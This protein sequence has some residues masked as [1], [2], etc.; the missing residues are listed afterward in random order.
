MLK[1][2]L[3]MKTQMKRM[4]S[5]GGLSARLSRLLRSYRLSVAASSLFVVA[6]LL[7]APTAKAQFSPGGGAGTG[8]ASIGSNSSYQPGPVNR[9]PIERVADGKVVSKTDTAMPG[10]VVYLKDAKSNSVKTYIA[11]DSG[12]FHFGQLSQNT[13]YTL[14]AES[15]GVKSKSKTIS[16]F[17]NR[18]SF[19][20]T[21]KVDGS[22]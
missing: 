12:H 7:C 6:G 8:G 3:F 5:R 15:N 21:L 20:F 14:W 16:S 4:S 17:D 1:M 19:N 9:G 22:K 11:D 18:N 10:A 2:P 13:D